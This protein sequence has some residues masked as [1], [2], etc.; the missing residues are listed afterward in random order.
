VTL[1]RAYG[2]H[3]SFR[4]NPA[5]KR[6]AIGGD[7]SG[8]RRFIDFCFGSVAHPR[9]LDFEKRF[10]SE[11]SRPAGNDMNEAFTAR[12]ELCSGASRVSRFEEQEL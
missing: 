1:G 9:F 7:P 3:V 6:R 10:A 5:L 4:S 2:T 8:I 12:L 11:S